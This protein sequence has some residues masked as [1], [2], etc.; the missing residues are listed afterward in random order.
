MRHKGPL[1]APNSAPRFPP[2]SNPCKSTSYKDG[3]LLKIITGKKE[4]GAIYHVVKSALKGAALI[5]I[6]QEFDGV[7]AR[8]CRL[9]P[10]ICY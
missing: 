4:E 1:N 5:V 8:D 9:I 3:G 6:L 10:R 2:F 7:Y